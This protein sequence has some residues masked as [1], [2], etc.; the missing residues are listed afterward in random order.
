MDL[1]IEQVEALRSQ[2]LAQIEAL[3][4][5]VGPTITV[6]AEEVVWA[7]L[8]SPLQRTVDWCDLKLTEYQPYE[9]RSQATT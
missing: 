4:A 8:L 6:G 9:V 1:N 5:T 3:L 2:A 7:P